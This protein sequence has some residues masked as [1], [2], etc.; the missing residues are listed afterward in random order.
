MI[1]IQRLPNGQLVITIPKRLAELKN[2]DKGTVLVFKDRDL[3]SL[4]I[5]KVGESNEKKKK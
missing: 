1:K 3:N 5:E 2:W 4:I